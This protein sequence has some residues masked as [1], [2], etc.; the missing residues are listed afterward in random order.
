MRLK[1]KR[2]KAPQIKF[3]RNSW[4]K[5]G[6]QVEDANYFGGFHLRLILLLP[7]LL[8]LT[9][10][11]VASNPVQTKTRRAPVFVAS[12]SFPVVWTREPQLLKYQ[13][14]RVNIKV[15]D[16][17]VLVMRVKVRVTHPP[18]YHAQTHSCLGSR[19]NQTFQSSGRGQIC[20]WG[21]FE[22]KQWKVQVW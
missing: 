15:V 6:F 7:L 21:C 10:D 17:E 22:V 4:S 12:L 9:V 20:T 8:L 18:V 3:S 19:R 13:D 5:V 2:R 1:A 11:V 14:M 16:F